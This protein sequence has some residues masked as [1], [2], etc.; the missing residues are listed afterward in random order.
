MVRGLQ[1]DIP[2]SESDLITS[3]LVVADSD[4]DSP[5]GIYTCVAMNKH[6]KALSER[7]LLLEAGECSAWWR[8]QMNTFSA[9]LALCVGNSPVP[10]NSP[11]KGQW[12]GAL[13]F[14]LIC[15][16]INGWVNNREAGDL[17]RY[18]AQYDVTVMACTYSDQ[19]GVHLKNIF[20]KLN[21]RNWL[22]KTLNITIDITYSF[23][24]PS[25]TL[26]PTVYCIVIVLIDL[27]VD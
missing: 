16:W 27:L 4:H 12:R 20:F 23:L 5:E 18:R 11:H 8:H 19:R 14:S 10:V 25:N 7:M 13:M 2:T 22:T 6:G 26:S 24:I 15:V 3:E 21:H 17:R 1:T 9:L